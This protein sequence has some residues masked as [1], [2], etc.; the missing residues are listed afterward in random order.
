MDPDLVQVDPPVCTG[1][2]KGPREG[3]ASLCKVMLAQPFRA[4]KIEAES[5]EVGLV[6]RM[7]LVPVDSGLDQIIDHKPTSGCCSLA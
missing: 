6:L 3:S 2:L 7:V 5:S 1:V 4:P